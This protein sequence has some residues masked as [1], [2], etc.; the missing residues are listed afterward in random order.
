MAW[1]FPSFYLFAVLKIQQYC[2][3]KPLL[4]LLD[5]SASKY[6]LNWNRKTVKWHDFRGII[7]SF[8]LWESE[9]CQWVWHSVCTDIKTLNSGTMKHNKTEILTK[10]KKSFMKYLQYNWDIFSS[11]WQC[12]SILYKNEISFFW[13]GEPASA[14][15]STTMTE[16]RS[17]QGLF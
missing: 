16:C 11:M 15:T 2:I 8:F 6:N 1:L 17:H 14:T 13:G 4:K 9:D 7:F 3:F 12:L 5:I 10:P